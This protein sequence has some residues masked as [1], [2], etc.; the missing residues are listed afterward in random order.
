MQYTK[1]ERLDIGRQ[2]YHGELT[3]MDLYCHSFVMSSI[4]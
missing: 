1:E 4:S 3:A 2:V